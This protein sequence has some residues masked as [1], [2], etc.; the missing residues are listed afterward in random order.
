MLKKQTHRHKATTTTTTTT[1]TYGY[2]RRKGWEFEISRYTPL[3][4]KI[5]KQQGPTV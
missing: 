3:Y 4:I 2:Q 5:D 1:T